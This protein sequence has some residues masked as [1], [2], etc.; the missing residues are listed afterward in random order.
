MER[1]KAVLQVNVKKI[2]KVTIAL[3]AITKVIIAKSTKMKRLKKPKRPRKS[4]LLKRKTKATRMS[5]QWSRK[6]KS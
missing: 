3:N 1:R 6:S 2:V 4:L 5:S